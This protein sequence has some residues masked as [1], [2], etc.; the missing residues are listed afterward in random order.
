MFACGVRRQKNE[1]ERKAK[2]GAEARE[3]EVKKRCE[4]LRVE[5][6]RIL[7]DSD[8]AESKIRDLK[9]TANQSR[10][11]AKKQADELERLESKCKELEQ[12]LL[13]ASA[14]TKK[15]EESQRKIAAA[16][17]E[18]TRVRDAFEELRA[19]NSELEKEGD[20]LRKS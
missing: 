20:K 14:F 15:H 3:A 16:V 17:A 7:C 5:I 6:D 11:F 8:S 13:G 18:A 4:S 9:A 19:K 2:C 12:K 1:A 10:V